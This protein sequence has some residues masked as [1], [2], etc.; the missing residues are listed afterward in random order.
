MASMRNEGA[1]IVEWLAWQHML[2]FTDAVVLTNDCTDRSPEL[3]EALQAAGRVRHVAC[4]IPPGQSVSAYKYRIAKDLP[5]VAGADWLLVCDVDEFLVIHRGAGLLADLIGAGDFLGMA[6]PWRVFGSS[7]IEH[8]A[9]L[10]VHRQFT[11]AAGPQSYFGRVIKTLHRSPRWFRRLGEH[12]PRGLDHKN[13]RRGTGLDWG[14]PD[15]AWVNAAGKRVDWQPD[16][17]YLRELPRGDVDLSVAQLS[18]YMLRSAESFSLKRGTLSPTGGK[19]RYTLDYWR[20]ADRRDLRDTSA[21]RHDAAF[22]AARAG[23]MALPGVARLHHLCVADHLRLI[24][25]KAGLRAE[26][27]PRHQMALERAA[28]Q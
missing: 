18:H 20:R 19:D 28:G 5:E 3:L 23:L 7:G 22:D 8:F 26:D 6:I 13:L 11:W 10:P 15:L 1:F 4:V 21:R 27:D 14:H 9:D 24:A 2:G 12:G 25:G 17:P 16:G